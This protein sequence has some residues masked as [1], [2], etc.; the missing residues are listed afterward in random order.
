MDSIAGQPWSGVRRHRDKPSYALKEA[1]T[2]AGAGTS[3]SPEGVLGV[4]SLVL[5]ALTIIVTLK[6][7]LLLLRADNQGE[8]GILSLMALAQKRLKGGAV[9]IVVLGVMGAALFYGDA[10]ITPA[11]SVLSAVEGLKLVTPGFQPYILYLSVAILALLFAVQPYG[12]A[13]VASFFGPIMA[14]W[15][16]TL[17][18]GGAIH[19]AD[20]PGV[21][22]ALHPMRGVDF[23]ATHGRVGLVALGAVFLAVTGAEAL[24]ADLGH[25][26]KRP[27]QAAWAFVVFPALAINYLGQGALILAHPEKLENPF[28]LLYPGWALLPMVVL[29]T[30][31]TVIASQAVIT[32]AYSLTQ[33]AIRLG[34]MP[35][36]QIRHTSGEMVGQIYIP[37]V[38]WILLVLVILLVGAF[39]SSSDLAAAYGIAVTGTMVITTAMAFVVV[40]RCWEW[41]PWAAALLVVPFLLVDFVFLC[42]NLLKVFEGGWIPLLIGGCVMVMMLSWHRGAAILQRKT[43]RLDL[44]LS[45]L[46]RTLERRNPNRVPGTAVFLTSHPENAPTALMHNLKHNK[47]LHEHNIVLSVVTDHR[48]RIPEEERCSAEPISENFKR[49]ILRFG[50]METP[51]VPVALRNCHALGANFNIMN[52]SFFLSRRALRTAPKSVMPYWQDKLF[53][54]LAHVASDAS[55]HFRIPTDRVVEVGTQ[56]AV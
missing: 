29:A 15:F 38:N 9:A 43:S 44:P 11:I 35:R 47:V 42:A 37:R 41:P 14:V 45:E 20:D 30:A 39:K 22:V 54:S 3:P 34:L 33:Q 18:T 31:A 52:T 7:V 8:G 32:G 17:T 19:I 1:V 13:R 25:F 51:N 46:V 53:V 28:F 49:V 10:V 40:W 26:G 12:T 21:L 23:L 5:W 2:A 16:A 55:E 56:V 6:Y 27:I 50:F 36:F 48:P 24:Y 4:L